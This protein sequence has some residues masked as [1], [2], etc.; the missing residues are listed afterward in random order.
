MPQQLVDYINQY[1][2]T[3]LFVLVVLQG[4]GI[5]I[6]PNELTLY[7][8]GYLAS[9]HNFS[10]IL[11][12]C[13]AIIAEILGA[14]F[15]YFIFYFFGDFLKKYK[16]FWVKVSSKK[17]NTLKIKII[18]SSNSSLLLL[19]LTPFIRGYICVIAGIL[20]LPYKVFIK[21]IVTSSILWT[22][23]WIIL[24]FITSKHFQFVINFFDSN[25]MLAILSIFIFLFTIK[26][27]NK[28]LTKKT[29]SKH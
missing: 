3:I 11:V 23:S 13:V 2:Y 27:T 18:K 21:I 5:P 17:I 25:A 20:H 16:P 24:G 12:L 26:K 8:F 15:V 9:L 28:H 7:Y 4:I 19:R 22:S 1:G 10:L 6:F 14:L 29:N